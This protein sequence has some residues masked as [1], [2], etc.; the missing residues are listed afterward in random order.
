MQ[1]EISYNKKIS[2]MILNIYPNDILILNLFF[3]FLSII[4]FRIKHNLNVLKQ[5][6]EEKR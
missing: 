4:I 3:I 2:K 5:K 1:E 6:L